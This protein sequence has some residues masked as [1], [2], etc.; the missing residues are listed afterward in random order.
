M[1]RASV[2]RA[3][4]ALDRVVGWVDLVAK[5]CVIFLVVAVTS[6]MLAQVFF[7]KVLNSSLQWSEELSLFG[8]VWIVWI[9]AV[10]LMRNWEHI[11]IPTF[12]DLVPKKHRFWPIALSK[13]AAIVFLALLIWYGFDVFT[14]RFH[15]RS[16]SLEISSR[17]AKLSI[18]VGA[19]FMALFAVNTMLR[20]VIEFRRRNFDHFESQ[21][22]P[23]VE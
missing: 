11:N 12:I 18:P 15:G 23:G 21:G 8:L 1:S 5:S 20:D 10:V 16:P 22:D 19:V 2:D 13:I 9:G 6:I 4:D 3:A 7:R 14:Q 17:W